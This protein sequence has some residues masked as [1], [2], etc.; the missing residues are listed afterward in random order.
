MERSGL[1]KTAV[2]AAL[3]ICMAASCLVTAPS[4]SG[5][6]RQGANETD[7]SRL[8]PAKQLGFL[9]TG[10]KVE[11]NSGFLKDMIYLTKEQ[12]ETLKS[13]KNPQDFGLGYSWKEN[14]R[15]S[16]HDDHGIGTYH[17]TI[18]DGLDVNTILDTVVRGG[19]QAID[20]YW[21]W[22]SGAYNTQ[23]ALENMQNLQYFGPGQ[24][25]GTP[26]PD[27][28]IACY[29]TTSETTD[30]SSGTEPAAAERLGSGQEVFVYGQ[31]SVNDDN[32][33]QFVKNANT[34]Y[35][36]KLSALLSSGSDK[37][38]ALQLKDLMEM[39]L[40]QTSYGIGEEKTHHLEG[41]PLSLVAD[42][43]GLN[44]YMPGYSG[45][46]LEIV[47][48][49]GTKVQ[50]T[51]DTM[52]QSFVAWGFTDNTGTPDQ[53]TGRLAVYMPGNIAYNLCKLNVVDRTGA[54]VTAVPQLPSPQAPAWVKAAKSSYDKI[55]LTW[56][57]VTGAEG[58]QVY[59][60][61]AKTGK[62]DKI[63]TLP[64]GSASYTDTG[65]KT[66]TTYKYRLKA[67]VTVS[68]T[69]YEGSY[70]REAFAKP[71]LDRGVIKKL[72]RSKKTAV[73]IKWKKVPGASG[74][75]IYRATRKSGKYKKVATIKKG[76]ATSYTNKKL[77]KRKTY[78]YRIR[79][80]RIVDGKPQ[81]GRF[82][83]VKKI[84]R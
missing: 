19:S 26:S 43:M 47:S 81:Y 37:F 80:Y 50:M 14:Q 34:I 21:I 83:T 1:K 59:R 61:S 79:P 22:S 4:V 49:D 41:V 38:A 63:R 45:N 9:I 32:N 54:L 8:K 58:Y 35:A 72:S 33:C 60:Y 76:G 82:S 15:Y 2:A 66:N 5:A 53:Q 11:G 10:N 42:K 29:K 48:Q 46:R 84:R 67:F 70:S 12:M 6:S 73:K 7:I 3:A 69:A 52:K 28:M 77:K 16:S 36:G 51:A 24:T 17:Y 20:T 31:N 68:G 56:A 64:A 75:Q 25:E 57:S 78:Y 30:P 23:F 44:K 39:G 74:Y 40:Y 65:L 13:E 27:P 18:A 55:K 71:Q 62:Y